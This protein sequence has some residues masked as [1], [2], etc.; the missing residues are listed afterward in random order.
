MSLVDG[1]DN[2]RMLTIWNILLNSKWEKEQ[3]IVLW[4]FL[5]KVMVTGVHLTSFMTT[6]DDV[7]LLLNLLTSAVN[8]GK[9]SG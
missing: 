3:R 6:A 7:I 4:E 9:V 2:Y 8:I 1:T 5:P